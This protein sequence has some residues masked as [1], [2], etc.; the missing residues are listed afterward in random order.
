MK[1]NVYFDS[2]VGMME[3]DHFF[4]FYESRI[5]RL[6]DEYIVI[7]PSGVDKYNEHYKVSQL[8]KMRK[9]QLQ[10]LCDL[11]NFTWYDDYTKADLID[12][13]MDVT[14]DLYFETYFKETSWRE[15]DESFVIRGNSQSDYIKVLNYK[16]ND[17][18]EE[19]LTNVFFNTPVS[20]TFES[21]DDIID[22]ND[23][24]DCVYNWDKDSVLNNIKKFKEDFSEEEIAFLEENLPNEPDWC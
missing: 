12:S 10:D 14:H 8:R 9:G 21:G 1:V 4:D 15:L 6:S 13:L 17:F 19:Y 20:A 18:C 2:V 7:L 11:Y 24:N 22:L 3:Y 5:L 23:Y 16:H